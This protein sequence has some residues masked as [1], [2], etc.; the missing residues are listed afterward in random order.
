MLLISVGKKYTGSGSV[1]VGNPEPNELYT[2]SSAEAT[3]VQC[4]N[5]DGTVSPTYWENRIFALPYRIQ[6]D[7]QL[8]RLDGEPSFTIDTGR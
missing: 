7:T 1:V 6:S 8:I 4:V 3:L 5:E 2:P